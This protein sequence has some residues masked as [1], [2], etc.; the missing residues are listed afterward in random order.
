M[1]TIRGEF[2]LRQSTFLLVFLALAITA[3]ASERLTL[4]VFPVNNATHVESLS[5]LSD[6]IAVSIS[7]QL[8]GS[9]SRVLSRRER[10]KLIEDLDLPPD[11]KISHA[12]MIRA[13]QQV[14]ADLIVMGSV[15][16][17]DRSL[18]ITLR[19]LDLK[20]LKLSGGMA[21]NGPLSAIAQ[22]ENDLAWQISSNAGL[23]KGRNREEFSKRTRR[24]PNSAYG[25]YIQSLSAPRQNDRLQLLQKATASFRNF[26]AAQ[27]ELGRLYYG[28]GDCE[29][30]Q[31]ALSVSAGDASLEA[32]SDFMRGTCCVRQGQF[33][34]AIQY[35]SQV[36]ST[37]KRFKATNNAGVALLRDGYTE[38]AIQA[39]TEA[40]RLAPADPAIALN[41]AV[42]HHLQGNNSVALSIVEDAVRI[43]PRSGM[44]HFLRGVLLG[45]QGES[46]G[47]A[48]AMGRAKSMGVDTDKLQNGRPASWCEL[49]MDWD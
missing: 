23:E 27:H 46:D 18:K 49:F 37:T 32:E 24:I 39:F 45:T 30:A 35:L 15:S 1:H 25:F 3:R 42:A 16:G 8:K 4:I 36:H 28:R 5:W 48:A 31:T 20:T 11:A 13:G 14:A 41:I 7:D 38:E 21:A 33:K 10:V 22:M 2:G 44:L 6:G 17:T 9:N 12:S 40:K 47:A 29:A 26:P 43:H 19:M 34:P